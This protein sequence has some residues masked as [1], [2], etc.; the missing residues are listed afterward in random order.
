MATTID[1]SAQLQAF[2]ARD[3]ATRILSTAGLTVAF[4]V[5]AYYQFIAT[6]D[7]SFVPRAGKAPGMFGLGLNDVKRDF[8]KNGTKIITEGYQNVRPRKDL[9][10]AQ[11]E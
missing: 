6:P 9:R 2:L 3:D 8:A 5:W 11:L 7:L 10:I 4:L 1:F